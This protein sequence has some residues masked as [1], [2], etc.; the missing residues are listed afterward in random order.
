MGTAVVWFA[1]GFA[2]ALLLRARVNN[3][4]GTDER[5]DEP[6]RTRTRPRP[7]AG[8]G[9]GRAVLRTMRTVNDIRA[10][11][12]GP[13]AYGRRVLRRQAFRTLRKW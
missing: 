10:I 12:R 4:N 7:R 6:A 13:G 1:V 11:S 2:V 5:A 9:T 8:T 3:R